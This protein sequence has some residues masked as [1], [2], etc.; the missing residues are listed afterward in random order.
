MKSFSKDIEARLEKAYQAAG[1]INKKYGYDQIKP[2]NMD[3][4]L[5]PSG[6][7]EDGATS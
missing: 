2:S 7:L 6:G 5:M 3:I 1:G 4:E